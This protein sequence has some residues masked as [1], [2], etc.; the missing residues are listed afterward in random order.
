MLHLLQF[1]YLYFRHVSPSPVAPAFG[2]MAATM[3][4]SKTVL[5]AFVDYYCGPNGWC[6][7]GHNDLQRWIVL[8]LIPNVRTYRFS[9]L[10]FATI[11]SFIACSYIPHIFRWLKQSCRGK[12][13]GYSRPCKSC[14]TRAI[15]LNP[16]P[17]PM[18]PTQRCWILFPFIIIISLGRVIWRVQNSR[19]PAPG[20]EIPSWH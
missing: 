6:T 19:R 16:H 2:F 3:T 20:S 8:Y 11:G 18:V 4:W 9:R 1:T 13:F 12:Q 17:G 10:L 5:Y 7:S 14:L 15:L